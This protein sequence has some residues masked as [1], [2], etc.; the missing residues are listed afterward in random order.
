MPDCA[1]STDVIA[2][3]CTE[4]EEE[5]QDTLSLMEEVGYEFAYMF[6]YSERPNTKAQRTLTDDIPEEVKTRRLNEIIELQ[7]KLSLK[8]NQKDI[9]KVFEV[10]VEG[11]SKRSKEEL[12]GRSSQYKVVVFPR[13]N[14][15]VGDLVKVKITQASSATLKGEPVE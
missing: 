5:H 12:F 6:K 9:G 1:I 8:S 4:T 3:F 13:K 15:K 11:T 7:N 2:G 14:Y 10:L